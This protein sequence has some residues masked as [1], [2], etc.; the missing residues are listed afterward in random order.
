[1]IRTH[2]P[3]RAL[4]AAGA[5]FFAAACES[6]PGEP[7]W[8]T[9]LPG[10][11]TLEAIGDS[12]RIGTTTSRTSAPLAWETSN[13]AVVTVNS[14]GVAT[15]TGPGTATVTARV[16]GA[17]ASSTVTVLPLTNVEVVNPRYETNLAGSPGFR[18]DLRN[19]G[20]RGFFRLEFWKFSDTPGGEPRRVLNEVGMRDVAVGMNSSTWYDS[21]REGSVDW[22]VVYS[23][24]PVSTQERRTSCVRVVG[25]AGCPLP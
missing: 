25:Q 9:L 13:P 6:D 14:S 4:V 7:A 21:F 10:S 17:H 16:Q 24:D 1:M 3:I 18:I 2:F 19:T 15:A 5:L 23:R 12:L 11:F 22:V 8:V 20:G